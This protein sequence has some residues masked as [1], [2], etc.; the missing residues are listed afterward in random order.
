M[1]ER[2]PQSPEQKEQGISRLIDAVNTD[3]HEK[4]EGI[5]S[6][7]EQKENYKFKGALDYINH[8]KD[9]VPNFNIDSWLKDREQ[10]Q[11][12]INIF[13]K[14]LENIRERYGNELNINFD[15]VETKSPID[16]TH[17]DEAKKGLNEFKA[18]VYEQIQ[19][20]IENAKNTK[21]YEPSKD[22]NI[23]QTRAEELI[24]TAKE[25]YEK[26]KDSDAP[27]DKEK[28][29]FVTAMEEK[30]RFIS[31]ALDKL[32]TLEK[33][34]KAIQNTKEDTSEIETHIKEIDEL[35]NRVKGVYEAIEKRYDEITAENVDIKQNLLDK[36]FGKEV[37]EKLAPALAQIPDADMREY[38]LATLMSTIAD[39]SNRDA[40]A[41]IDAKTSTGNFFSKVWNSMT[42]NFGKAN[43]YIKGISE[44]IREPNHPVI[45]SFID[46]IDMFE[47]MGPVHIVDKNGTKKFESLYAK[48]P[49]E[50]AT[51]ENIDKTQRNEL[52]MTISLIHFNCE[53]YRESVD[54]LNKDASERQIADNENEF[55]TLKAKAF[56]QYAEAFKVAGLPENKIEARVMEEIAGIE[57]RK[58]F[59]LAER[60]DPEFN[61]VI[62]KEFIQS[63]TLKNWGKIA[64]D[65]FAQMA[66]MA[67]GGGIRFGIKTGGVGA[68]AGLAAGGVGATTLAPVLITLAAGAAAGAGVGALMGYYRGKKTGKEKLDDESYKRLWGKMEEKGAVMKMEDAIKAIKQEKTLEKTE[69]FIKNLRAENITSH[70]INEI[71]QIMIQ[72]YITGPDETKEKRMRL[73]KGIGKWTDTDGNTHISTGKIDKFH[74]LAKKIFGTGKKGDAKA[75]EAL[76]RLIYPEAAATHAFA[77]ADFQAV[78]KT[79]DIPGEGED[80]KKIGIGLADK[81]ERKLKRVQALKQEDINAMDEEERI[82]H[83]NTMRREQQFL[84]ARIDYTL[85]KLKNNE[86]AFS[87]NEQIAEKY[88]LQSVVLLAKVELMDAAI[89]ENAAHESA[90]AKYLHNK[91][92]LANRT[93]KAEEKF[94][95]RT[96]RESVKKGLAYGALGGLVGSG[97]TTWLA[98]TETGQDL[99]EKIRDVIGIGNDAD[100]GGTTA[101]PVDKFEPGG[102]DARQESDTAIPDSA[103]AAP[104]STSG[105]GTGGGN[106]LLSNAP[107]VTPP[108]QPP[109]PSNSGTAIP[110]E[111]FAKQNPE[112]L[113]KKGEGITQLFARLN[114][115]TGKQDQLEFIKPFLKFE[116][117]NVVGFK[118]GFEIQAVGADGQPI[119][120]ITVEGKTIDI[121]K[122]DWFGK[123]GTDIWAK[124]P[125]KLGME[126]IKDGEG[127]P[128]G[129]KLITAE[130]SFMNEPDH[131]PQATNKV[132][133]G[134]SGTESAIETE[135]NIKT[136]FDTSNV[137]N[138]IETLSKEVSSLQKDL[139]TAQNVS[140]MLWNFDDKLD[141]LTDNTVEALDATHSNIKTRFSELYDNAGT[142]HDIFEKGVIVGKMNT[143]ETVYSQNIANAH[144]MKINSIEQLT[145]EKESML[146]QIKSAQKT[147][148]ELPTSH[149]AKKEI[150][151]NI[152]DDMQEIEQKYDELIG[153]VLER[154]IETT[155]RIMDALFDGYDDYTSHADEIIT[156]T[157]GEPIN[158]KGSSPKDIAGTMLQLQ[159]LANKHPEYQSIYED[160]V[161]QIDTRSF[162]SEMKAYIKDALGIKP[163]EETLNTATESVINSAASE[164]QIPDTETAPS[165]S[166]IA[167][168]ELTD[169][170]V[171]EMDIEKIISDPE[172]WQKTYDEIKNMPDTEKRKEMIEKIVQYGND[173][174]A[175]NESMNQEEYRQ[176][177]QPFRDLL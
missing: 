57:S 140:D 92:I 94:V 98:N 149:S 172:T 70:E 105:S 25:A 166:A 62:T 32:R 151:E 147:V 114:G 4:R 22:P 137:Q 56:N 34:L 130:D 41:R 60:L 138:P 107:P 64:K 96:T 126:V 143:P 154:S 26:I 47:E 45:K 24:R 170:L 169:T 150:L 36:G 157:N 165:E 134:G 35:L 160:Y 132:S 118:D 91:E 161:Q 144:G 158:Y 174:W 85:H 42:K 102:E 128:I 29:A 72:N 13:I 173:A 46:N 139:P 176:Y 113:V 52:A 55:K 95:Q 148:S 99:V 135:P 43:E 155:E 106:N 12:N 18:S 61:E 116:D 1:S 82:A 23:N 108:N 89:T 146:N 77:S 15:E 100:T 111:D 121:D 87:S 84:K 11:S 63:H 177:I 51:S 153:T 125:E 109:V 28:A 90:F 71:E 2:I 9:K 54:P 123:D 33:E 133:T 97:F 7:Y 31:N 145:N 58:N 168:S 16:K 110:F 38:A 156:N 142:Q 171:F 117:G 66:T 164:T 167:N 141:E 93:S 124:E 14:T 68:L 76:L 136:S 122:A 53:K 152:A 81:L 49:A 163:S 79:K 127:K 21:P 119:D 19:K 73:L 39:Q 17:Q 129:F 83:E 67:A 20:A 115:A 44:G 48:I 80:T 175:M 159:N 74:T 40:T 10:T 75:E 112:Q 104:D 103:S 30:K 88:A 50:I 120:T 131:I 5:L 6:A 37:A 8:F 86:I 27:S 3:I 59:G 78:K 65:T 162:T 69:S 101:P